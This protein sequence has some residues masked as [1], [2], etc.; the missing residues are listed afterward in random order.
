MMT[1]Y[2]VEDQQVMQ[3]FMV[4]LIEAQPMLKLAGQSGDGQAAL[5]ECMR[6]QPDIILLDVFLPGLNGVDFLK[7][8]KKDIP[9]VKV[10]GFSAFPSPGI[11]KQMVEAG[12]DGLVRKTESLTVLEQALEQVAAGQTFFSPDVVNMLRDMM[13]H[14]ERIISPDDLSSRERQVVQ[15]I[16]EGKSNKEISET[17]SISIKTTETHR[18]NIMRKLDL[19]DAVALT[20]YAIKHG[21]VASSEVA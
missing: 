3:D 12:A 18:T 10:L 4:R 16:A 1:V 15:L 9:G 17:L 14:P 6:L 2:I 21:L 5:R 13:L 11:V 7:Q 19:H 8:L 20:R